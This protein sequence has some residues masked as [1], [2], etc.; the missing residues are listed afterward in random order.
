MVT[1]WWFRMFS[2]V[3]APADPSKAPNTVYSRR[4][5][6]EKIR[7]SLALF[8][9]RVFV[10]HVQVV[11]GLSAATALCSPAFSSVGRILSIE[12]LSTR[13]TE[14]RPVACSPRC[15]QWE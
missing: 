9:L 1:L 6:A 7:K 13:G 14:R 3:C 11:T 12:A 8:A 2:S 15:S 5:V 4:S 10:G